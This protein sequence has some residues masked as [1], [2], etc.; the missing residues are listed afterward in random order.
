MVIRKKNSNFFSRGT[1]TAKAKGCCASTS[2]SDDK[3]NDMIRERAY[4]L[5]E[6]LG[7]PCGQDFDIWDKAEKQIRARVKR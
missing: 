4:Y 1:K 7:R 6:E 5:W 2:I 3:L